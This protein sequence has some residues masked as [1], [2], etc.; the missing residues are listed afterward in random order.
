MLC[1][2][3]YDVVKICDRWIGKVMA[4]ECNILNDLLL[5]LLDPDGPSGVG[6]LRSG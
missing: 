5:A 2:L 4:I 1:E 3:W 6:R